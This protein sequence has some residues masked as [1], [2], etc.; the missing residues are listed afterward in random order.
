MG[1]LCSHRALENALVVMALGSAI[2][3]HL[4]EVSF[5]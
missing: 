2:W 5:L 3:A 1:G 4:G